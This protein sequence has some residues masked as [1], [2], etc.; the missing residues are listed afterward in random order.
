MQS[1]GGGSS[2]LQKEVRGSVGIWY[3][4]ASGG[5]YVPRCADELVPLKGK[6]EMPM[7]SSRSV[8]Q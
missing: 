6:E 7:L 8:A 2:N 5:A 4:A 1:F 3:P